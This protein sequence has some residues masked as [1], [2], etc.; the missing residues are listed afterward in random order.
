MTNS[1]IMSSFLD[2]FSKLLKLALRKFSI[3][4]D[5]QNATDTEQHDSLPEDPS[6][7]KQ[8]RKPRPSWGCFEFQDIA[9]K[10][11]QMKK[12]ME[13]SSKES[14][15]STDT[16]HVQI[17]DVQTCITT[18]EEPEASTSNRQDSDCSVWSDNIPVITISKTESSENILKDDENKKCK[19]KKYEPRI[20]CILKKQSTEIDED[21]I[22]YFNNE[23]ERNISECGAMKKLSEELSDINEDNDPLN[24]NSK[25]EELLTDKS[26][27]DD[28]EKN[29][30]VET[31]LNFSSII[32]E[33]I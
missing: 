15:S 28:T 27:S 9:N 13:L 12:S 21:T 29:G 6:V 19:I 33:P 31:I 10:A 2:F 3:S 7:G 25:T 14:E 18:S 1:M 30:S 8:L 16:K 26:S 24:E 20:R 4:E 32:D 11:L 17:N 22:R 23:I 5:D